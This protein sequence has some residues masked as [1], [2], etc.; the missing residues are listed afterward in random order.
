VTSKAG[1]GEGT[2]E[3]ET[4]DQALYRGTV[5][6]TYS[7]HGTGCGQSWNWSY[8]G[9]L[10][11]SAGND[12]PF[13]I[14]DPPSGGPEIGGAAGYDESLS[15]TYSY[16]PCGNQPGCSHDMSIAPGHYGFLS[17]EANGDTIY[18]T[19]EPPSIDVGD[20]DNDLINVLPDAT[21]PRSRIGDDT[22]TLHFPYDDGETVTTGTLTLT[23]VDQS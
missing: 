6:A 4:D 2:W 21:F 9:R 1:V 5:E 15:G 20:C 7:V 12:E 18:A 3:Q 8:S 11:D 14:L 10:A 22:I 19:M 16:P 17:F 23:R 13:A